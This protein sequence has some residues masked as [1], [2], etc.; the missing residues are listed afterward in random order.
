MDNNGKSGLGIGK[1][2]VKMRKKNSEIKKSITLYKNVFVSQIGRAGCQ[3]EYLFELFTTFQ[4]C[5][6]PSCDL[7]LQRKF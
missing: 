5:I 7:V 2:K 4:Y 1:N 3:R 6:I